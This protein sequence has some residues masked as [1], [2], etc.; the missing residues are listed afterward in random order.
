VSN[1]YQCLCNDGFLGDGLQNGTGCSAVQQVSVTVNQQKPDFTIS[2]ANSNSGN[3]GDIPFQV[4]VVQFNELDYYGR[5]VQT[6]NASLLQWNIVNQNL[7]DLSNP[8]NFYQQWTFYATVNSTITVQLNVSISNASVVIPFGTTTL[9]LP[10]QSLKWALEISLWPFLS[11]LNSLSILF[12]SKSASTSNFVVPQ[13]DVSLTSTGNLE[14]FT[15][16]TGLSALYCSINPVAFLDGLSSTAK[17][18]YL[19]LGEF[20]AIIPS[21]EE[22]AL[23]DPNFAIVL[24][25]KIKGSNDVTPPSANMFPVWEWVVVTVVPVFGVAIVIAAAYLISKNVKNWKRIKKPKQ[26]EWI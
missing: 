12:S 1:Q 8:S 9:V 7:T 3:L 2:S 15:L 18:A 24:G 5:T 6:I 21:F 13:D 14:S 16:D 26:S 22:S 20:S 11:P 25:T 23:I 17:F 10:P 19:N 4:A